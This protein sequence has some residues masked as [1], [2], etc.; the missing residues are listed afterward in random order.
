MIYT[1]QLANRR[2][3]ALSRATWLAVGVAVLLSIL[4]VLAGIAISRRIGQREIRR[5]REQ[6]ELRELLQVSASEAESQSLLIRTSSAPSPARPPRCST[7]ITPTTV[8]R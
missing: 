3:R 4:L 5:Q 1:S 8:S 2:D 6:R 7:A